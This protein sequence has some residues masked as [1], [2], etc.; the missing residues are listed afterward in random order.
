MFNEITIKN[1]KS[2]QNATIKLKNVNILIGANNSGKSNL[3]EVFELY[4]RVLAIDLQEVFGPGP[5]SYRSVFHR[6]KDIRNDSIDLSIHYQNNQFIHHRFSIEDY[7]NKRPGPAFL[8]RIKEEH[9]I[10]G[11]VET[12]SYNSTGLLLRNEY[13]S[14]E[15]KSE[16]LDYFKA[17]RSI[18]KFQFIPKVI[19]KEQTVDTLEQYIPFLD[20]SG[21]NLVNVLYNI[22]DVYPHIFEIIMNDFKEIYPDVMNLSFKHLGESKYALE[23]TR[24][25]EGKI[26]KFLGPEISDG[27]VITLAI[28]TLIN[29]PNSPK[30]ILIE[31]IENG[32]N[33][34]TL[35]IILERIMKASVISDIQFLIT[36]HSPILLEL[37][38]QSPECIIVCEQEN[39]KSKYIPL[40]QILSKFD[41]DYIEGESLFQLWF[42]GLIGG[43]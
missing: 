3:L 17:C 39:G 35:R 2:I 32:L 4:Q 20:A 8:L 42:N 9:F 16:A 23:F 12:K 38:S 41:E 37:L 33:P 14:H 5:Y 11:D 28:I 36:T 43:L 13:R 21:E 7:R 34:S 6:G 31:E 26:W 40:N 1:F 22:R 29:T 24:E 19:K 10:V 15:L 18:R 27:F 30:M 25:V